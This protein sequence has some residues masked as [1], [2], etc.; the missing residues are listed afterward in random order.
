MIE[1]N[2]VPDVKQELIRAQR[3][4][5]LVVS[6]SIVASLAAVGVVVL[7][8]LY[9]FGVQTLRGAIADDAIEK[10]SQ[11]L[12]S[13]EDLSK[14]LTIQNQLKQ[15]DTLH[16]DKKTE[17]RLFDMLSAVLPP[18]PNQVQ[19]ATLTLDSETSNLKIEGQTPTYDTLEVFKKTI[20]GA[21]VT[22]TEDGTEQS[23]KLADAISI[24]DVSFGE[25]MNGGKVLRFTISF[26]YPEVLFSADIPNVVIKLTNSGN[27]T[28]SYLGVPRSIFVSGGQ[29]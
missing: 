20:D 4:R 18:A 16:A 21:V 5:A 8:S 24:S 11:E 3:Q 29:N 23:V 12:A 7:L 10:N 14:V 1:I 6:F 27:A 28:D 26:T 2:L 17:S 9:V 15:I 25:D 19:I 13:V 22:Y